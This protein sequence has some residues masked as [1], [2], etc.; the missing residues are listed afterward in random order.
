MPWDSTVLEIRTNLGQTSYTNQKIS[1]SFCL[2]C[3]ELG[4]LPF[5][6]ERVLMSSLHQSSNQRQ[7]KPKPDNHPTG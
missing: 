3:V 4:C 6:A 5:A 1:L 7:S 2:S